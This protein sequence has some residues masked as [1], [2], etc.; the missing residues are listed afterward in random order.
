VDIQAKITSRNRDCSDDKKKGNGAMSKKFRTMIVALLLTVGLAAAILYSGCGGNSGGGAAG[1]GGG[2]DGTPSPSPSPVNKVQVNISVVNDNDG[3]GISESLIY[4]VYQ[5]GN[6]F[7]GV[8]D[9]N[10][11]W[12]TELAEGS[13][14]AM[15]SASGYEPAQDV[16]PVCPTKKRFVL[17]LK[18]SPEGNLTGMVWNKSLPYPYPPLSQVRITIT[19]IK[20]NSQDPNLTAPITIYNNYMG[21][22]SAAVSAGIY[23]VDLY[24]EG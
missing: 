23:K 13:Y 6:A 21:F 7:S 16:L 12:P 11:N 3:I 17:R 5:A 9:Q 24:K 1:G 8:T 20:N 14:T 10:G 22:Y 15:A 19:Q 18:K 4:L 2:D